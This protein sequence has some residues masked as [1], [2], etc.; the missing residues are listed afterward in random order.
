MLGAMSKFRLNSLCSKDQNGLFKVNVW[1]DL[2][3]SDF[4]HGPY[5]RKSKSVPA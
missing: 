4:G 1:N 2:F 5:S 3:Q